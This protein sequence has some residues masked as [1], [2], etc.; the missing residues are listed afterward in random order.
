[1]NE[2]S[3]S[4]MLAAFQSDSEAGIQA[5]NAPLSGARFEI[6]LKPLPA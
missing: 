5:E 3:A 2:V 1:M 4:E 6:W